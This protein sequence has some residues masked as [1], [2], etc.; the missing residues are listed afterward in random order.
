MNI[1]SIL[2]LLLA[3][4]DEVLFVSIDL[5]ISVVVIRPKSSISDV[6]FFSCAKVIP[7]YI[8]ST[9]IVR[10]ALVWW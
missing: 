1:Y 2:D 10:A 4:W 9:H 3:I 5:S 6:S 7:E 8:D